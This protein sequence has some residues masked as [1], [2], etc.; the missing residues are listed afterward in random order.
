MDDRSVRVLLRI[1]IMGEAAF[2]CN[3]FVRCLHQVDK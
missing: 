1:N 2:D 3:R